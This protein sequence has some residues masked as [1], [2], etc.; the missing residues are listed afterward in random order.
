MSYARLAAA[1]FVGTLASPAWQADPADE[2]R[3]ARD[4]MLAQRYAEAVAIYR[5]MIA[6]DGAAP[7]L[8]FNLALA[9]HSA[10]RYREAVTE[11]ELIRTAERANSRYWFLLGLGYLK[12]GEPRKAVE[13]LGN[14]ARLDPSNPNARVE[15]ADAWL[16]SG[17]LENAEHEFRRL[18][19]EHADLPKVWEGL[20]LSRFG[21][22]RKAY[23]SLE[24]SSPSES[25]RYGLAA[26]AEAEA[27]HTAKAVEAYEK[28]LAAEP[29][30]PWMRAE[31][32]ALRHGTGEKP[33]VVDCT[34]QSLA[35]A[36][37]KGEW[38]EVTE[39]A[40]KLL[41]PEALYWTCRA[42]SQLGRDS[43]EKL[44]ALPASAEQHQM[45]ARAYSSAGRK[46]EAIIELREAER[47]RPD[48]VL[49]LGQLAKALWVERKYDEAVEMLKPLVAGNPDQA[50]WQFELGDALVSMGKPEDAAS[51]LQKAVTLA[52]DLLPAQA[53]L[54]ELLLE[55]G[56]AAQAV[57]HLERAENLDQDGSLHYQLAM[58]YRRIGKTDLASQALARQRELQQNLKN[59][60][61]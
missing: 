18:A 32:I 56:D 58:A 7:E 15:L 21:L 16:E 59:H 54:G 53:K 9:L 34:S 13:P 46:N 22:S 2:A 4:A 11:L 6:A 57:P 37:F 47:L 19:V 45:L 41:T 12:L 61:H 29:P 35:C 49:I 27:G 44:A 51:H 3:R 60:S 33:E 40:G 24:Q 55:M 48:D 1:L 28:A 23:A 36:F 30:A 26:V 39:R 52:P 20:A 38:L 8:H 50:D 5:K 14:A 42:Y 31:L 17:D 25:L 43:M 10:G